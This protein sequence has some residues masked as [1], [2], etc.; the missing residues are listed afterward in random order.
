M[1]DYTSRMNR[2]ILEV[3]PSGIRKFFD[4]AS[5]MDDVIS[6]SIGEPDFTTPFHVRA[7][8]IKTLEQG[9]TFYS[10][11]RGFTALRNEI[12]NWM[13]RKYN[14]SYNPDTEVLVTV[15]GSEAIDMAIRTLVNPG[16]EVLIPEPSFVCYVPMTQMAKG[17]PVIIETK[18]EDKF[19]LTAKALREKITPKT[20]L[21]ILPFPNNPTGGIMR[22][23]D[24]EEI[25]AVVKEH[26][27]LVISDEIY[28]EL[29]YGGKSHVCFSEIEGMRERTI[30]INGFSKTFAMTGWRLGFAVGPEPILSAMTKL[31]QYA[32]MSAPTMAQYAAIEALKNGDD[33]IVYMRDQYDMRRRLIVS[34]FNDMG[35]TCFEP[36]GAFYVFPCIKSTSLSSEEFCEK[37][38]RESRVAVVPGNAFGACGEGY[39]RVS[40]SYSLKHINIALERIREFIKNL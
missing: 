34:A 6:L 31:H 9:K 23:E 7:E 2:E 15:G 14:V 32:I 21:L 18:E 27:L 10:P 26:D 24:L 33:D 38:I 3:K 19:R 20:K 35:L 28:S 16:D 22:R 40:Y 30:V 17:V 1:I 36:E 13:Q 37:L 8:G 29:T 4:I 25:A 11:N 5:E 39:V 12:T